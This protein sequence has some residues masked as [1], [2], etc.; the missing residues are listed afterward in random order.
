MIALEKP[1]TVRKSGI[2]NDGISF[3]IKK[4][5]LAHIFN[6][7][8]NQLYS[9]KILAV[10]R[11]YSCNAYD[12]QVEAGNSDKQFIVTCPTLVRSLLQGA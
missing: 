5:G 9:N 10:I 1:Y 4:E 11:E 7:L 8:R 12:A 2:E 6:V 3:G